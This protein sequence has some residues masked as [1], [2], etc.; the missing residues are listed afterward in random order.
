MTVFTFVVLLLFYFCNT[1]FSYYIQRQNFVFFELKIRYQ[2]KRFDY[3]PSPILMYNQMYSHDNWV[4]FRY[5]IDRQVDEDVIPNW[6]SLADESISAFFACMAAESIWKV[7]PAARK[8]ETDPDLVIPAVQHPLEDAETKNKIAAFWTK[9]ESKKLE[10]KKSEEK[11]KETYDFED[12]LGATFGAADGEETVDRDILQQ[13]TKSI[14]SFSLDNT[15]E[16]KRSD[17][18]S[19]NIELP[20]FQAWREKRAQIALVAKPK[21]FG[22]SQIDVLRAR[23][24]SLSDEKNLKNVKKAGDV[25]QRF[26]ILRE[27]LITAWG[28]EDRVESF[29][30]VIESAN[31]LQSIPPQSEEY[32][33][34]WLLAIDVVDTFGKLLY[35]RLLAKSN[36]ARNKNGQTDLSANFTVEQVPKNVKDMAMNW[37]LKLSEIIDIPIRFYIECS[38]IA[39]LKFFD[40]ANL[41][42]NLE[43][44]AIMCSQFND[45]LSSI[46]A[47]VHIT[48]YSMLIDPLNR[49]PHWR[50][51]HDWM[52]APKDVM[53][54]L[55]R[56]KTSLADA[57]KEAVSIQGVS[58]IVQC[59][60][61]GAHTVDDLVPLFAYCRKTSPLDEK[62]S[63]W[64]RV[65]DISNFQTFVDCC[66]A[67]T[68]YITKYYTLKEV[69]K[70][71]ELVL[72]RLRIDDQTK[73]PENT[74]L[75]INLIAA[76]LEH[77]ANKSDCLDIVTSNSFIK[78]VD[79][80]G[81]DI[82]ST[83]D[84]SRRILE[85]FSK[86]FTRHT[87]SDI[88]AC[89]F[90]IEKCRT[91]CKA[92]RLEESEEVKAAEQL[93]CSSL[94]LIDFQAFTNLDQCIELIV[95]CRED[96][97]LR[98]NSL[99]HI[100]ETLFN[101]T[102]FIHRTQKS[103]KRKADF[104]RVCITNLSLTIPAVRD[105]SRRVKMTVQNIQMCLLANF[106]PQM[107]MSSVRVI[108]YLDE[109]STNGPSVCATVSPLISQFLATLSFCPEGF[110]EEM[111][112][113]S[114]FSKILAIVE[115]NHEEWSKEYKGVPLAEIYINMLRYLCTCRKVDPL[116]AD[117]SQKLHFGDDDHLIRV[118]C[119]I[120][121]VITK[122]FSLANDPTI[123]VITLENVVICA[124]RSEVF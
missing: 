100:I 119:N 114:H 98:Q 28:R 94:S 102:Q 39:C 109:M 107:E 35:D 51:L 48:R 71:L 46:F 60:A 68:S 104:M 53:E 92:Y 97:G 96:M 112:S 116:R 63:V 54:E 64:M 74:A 89:Q 61:H 72:V 78:I 26:L 32:P 20:E 56:K 19:F 77:N 37:F 86:T 18:S 2:T 99:I 8:F 81:Y 69:T 108:E 38:M 15:L 16:N 4:P 10:S 5:E 90:I 111:P 57:R 47:R 22:M 55:H 17:H 91:L 79:L 121:D 115:R 84:C 120:S 85:I 80:I 124:P 87:I 59:V 33:Y 122:L 23:L 73:K 29:K 103:G 36:E 21:E 12:P 34:Y 58:W 11:G 43:R 83:S 49:T 62:T 45:D 123:A 101:F 75:L 105:P 76:F 24:K 67:W 106:L 40:A 14:R 41:S 9:W 3:D 88:S 66:A 70:I 42:I 6:E 93:V 27:N 30:I 65:A 110:N 52:Q 31:L 7:R 44:L 118:D 13:S 95:R 25:S 113:L 1:V 117:S 50:V 82:Q